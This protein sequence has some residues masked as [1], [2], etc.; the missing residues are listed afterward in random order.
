M[1]VLAPR[2]VQLSYNATPPKLS[3]A[4]QFSDEV[5]CNE[6]KM[7]VASI[8]ERIDQKP[9]RPFAVETVGGSWVDVEDE[10]DIYISR[11]KHRIVIFDP[12]G[13]MYI[14]EPEQIST[15]EAK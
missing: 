1:I 13:R 6:S 11:R 8:L 2:A 7:T 14:L 12:N 10:A 5:F 15:I 3:F 4:L 9:F